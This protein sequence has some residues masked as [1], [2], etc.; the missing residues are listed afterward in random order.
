MEVD[1]NVQ[2]TNIL[3]R[4]ERASPSTD[5][6]SSWRLARLPG[7]GPEN[8]SFLFKLLH[9]ILPKQ[10]RV[11]RTKPRAS[12]ACPLPGCDA[13]SETHGLVLCEGN[14]GVGQMSGKLCSS[15]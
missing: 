6:E 10:E 3:C 15:D 12:P 1:G 8:V 7:L 13:A 9:D 4:V 2:Q 5:W 11:A 14:N